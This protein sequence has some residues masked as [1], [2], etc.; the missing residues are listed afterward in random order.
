M[1]LP[2]F[3]FAH[4]AAAAGVLYFSQPGALAE[5]AVL[6][7]PD[8]SPRSNIEMPTD[9]RVRFV[10]DNLFAVDFVSDS[11]GWAGGYY[12]TLL[13]TE[14]GGGHWKREPL[15]FVEPINLHWLA[16]KLRARSDEADGLSGQA[17]QSERE[18]THRSLQCGDKGIPAQRR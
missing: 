1:N 13:K 2:V 9:G 11:V 17:N 7:P 16:T 10:P 18:E 12:G 14:D 15:P 5:Q 8:I 3:K 4:A 6:S